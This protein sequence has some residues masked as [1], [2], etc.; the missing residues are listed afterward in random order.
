MEESKPIEQLKKFNFFLAEQIAEQV[1]DPRS[2]PIR[3]TDINVTDIGLV[4]SKYPFA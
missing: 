3:L 2:H 4:K 1:N